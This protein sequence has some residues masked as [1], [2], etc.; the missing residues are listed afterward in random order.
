MFKLLPDFRGLRAKSSQDSSLCQ[1]LCSQVV[2]EIKIMFIKGKGRSQ[3][4]KKDDQ[5]KDD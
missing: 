1:R 2:K 5:R 4:G 3:G